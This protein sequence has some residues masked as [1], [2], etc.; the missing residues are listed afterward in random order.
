[1]SIWFP[2][3]IATL[4]LLAGNLSTADEE[5]PTAT[6]TIVQLSVFADQ[7][8]DAKPVAQCQGFVVEADGMILTSYQPLIDPATE[9]LHPRI[10]VAGLVEFSGK[11]LSASIVAV[12]PTLNF[13]ILNVETT[14]KLKASKLC[15]RE[16]IVVGAPIHART[17]L[18]NNSAHLSSGK[19]TDLNSMECY[20][21]TMTAT[22]LQAAIKVPDAALGG[23]LFNNKGE[24]VAIHT[25]YSKT[26]EDEP[27]D[28]PEIEEGKI[29]ILPI[30]LV[31]N[32]Y[33]A[34]KLK[35]NMKSPWTGFSVRPLSKKEKSIF[36]QGRF[37]G[38]VGIDAVWPD[39]PADKLGIQKDDMLVAFSY[40]PTENVA[41]FQK[42]LYMYG[43]G[44]KVKLHFI[45][46]ADKYFSV[47]YTIEERP[48]SARP[49]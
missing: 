8:K 7:E 39:S 16:K 45:R 47:D 49:R 29:H 14:K 43:V 48:A 46:G 22:M 41:A 10:E 15:P 2:I 42:W 33:E 37:S 40:Y 13:A 4:L 38:G 17:T 25:G 21:E 31:F 28:G 30:F 12:E 44:F 36:P 26:A 27:H 19:I 34:V 24:V 1:M 35:G 18:V 3:L 32:I 20:Q 23:P 5:Q 11:S 9:A 6:P